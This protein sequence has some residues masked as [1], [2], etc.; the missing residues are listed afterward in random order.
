SS[1][2][3]SGTTS[4]PDLCVCGS[5]IAIRSLRRRRRVAAALN[6]R[7]HVDHAQIHKRA[8]EAALPF[9]GRCKVGFPAMVKQA[10]ASGKYR[11]ERQTCLLERY[12]PKKSNIQVRT[13]SG[14]KA[15]RGDV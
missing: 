13:R 15:I 14:S 10:G 6:A 12:G 8:M 2:E 4:S 7:P 5:R 3:K 9:G 11:I 1:T